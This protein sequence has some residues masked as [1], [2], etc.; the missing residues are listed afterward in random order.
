MSRRIGWLLVLAG[1]ASCGD[2]AP[3]DRRA[4]ACGFADPALEEDDDG[5][6][7]IAAYEGRGD[8]D[9]DGLENDQDTDADGDGYSDAEEIGTRIDRCYP[10]VDTDQDAL[11]DVRDTDSDGDGLLDAEERAAGTD[12]LDPDSDADGCPD[13]AEEWLDGCTDP[14][15]LALRMVCGDR[16][17]TVIFP[18][19]GPELASVSLEVVVDDDDDPRTFFSIRTFADAVFPAGSASL[20]GEASDGSDAV[21]TDVA[22][23][24]SL[25]FGVEVLDVR[26][27][28]PRTMGRLELLGPGGELLDTGRL[29]IL[30]ER[31]CAARRS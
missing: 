3:M 1:L 20:L 12:R 9:G 24:A 23:G 17:A 14:R 10:P 31:S 13:G 30:G 21:F 28:G 15:D 25:V 4:T 6:G 2:V 18:W 27:E 26:T 16:F 29:L 19:D 7:L 5:D 22:P 11:P 8:D